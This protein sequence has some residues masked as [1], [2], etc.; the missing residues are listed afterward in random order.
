MRRSL[1]KRSALRVSAHPR[2]P[3]TW[4]SGA[5][6]ATGTLP[7]VP[8]LE[9]DAEI[10]GAQER[11]HLLERVLGRAQ[12]AQLLPLDLHLHLL[13]LL[14]ADLLGDLLR[15][16]RV[17]PLLEPDHLPRAPH[18]AD[19]DLLLVQVLERHAALGE[20]LAQ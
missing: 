9:L 2:V 19:L 15:G 10:L 17:D 3:N 12:H 1:K 5:P 8:E 11:H 6:P 13:E 7:V 16:L 14:I 4:T 18:R 20:L